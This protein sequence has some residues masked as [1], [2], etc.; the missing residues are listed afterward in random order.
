[1]QRTHHADNAVDIICPECQG[2]WRR[3]LDVDTKKAQVCKTCKGSGKL[4]R[5]VLV[6][7]AATIQVGSDRYAATVIWVSPSGHQIKL[8]RDKATPTAS[9]AYTEDQTYICVAN[10]SGEIEKAQLRHA[11]DPKVQS[12]FFMC[13]KGWSGVTLGVKSPYRDPSF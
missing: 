3:R 10:P 8:Q 7:D 13:G 12:R 11:E 4:H 2:D 9:I 6:G 1:M 5:K